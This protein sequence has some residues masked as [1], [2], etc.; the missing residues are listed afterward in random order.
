MQRKKMTL[1]FDLDR[2]VAL[3]R[4]ANII[5]DGHAVGVI[6]AKIADQAAPAA[7]HMEPHEGRVVLTLP[8]DAE[9]LT[10]ARANRARGRRRDGGRY[11]GLSG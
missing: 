7:Q 2:P 5:V 11:H 4:G 8:Q 9:N 6:L 1:R 10:H 3:G